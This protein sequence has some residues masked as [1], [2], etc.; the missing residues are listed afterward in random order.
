MEEEEIIESLTIQNSAL[1]EELGH[2]KLR[3]SQLEQQLIQQQKEYERRF[4]LLLLQKEQLEQNEQFEKQKLEQNKQ[5]EKQKSEQNEQLEQH[6]Q[7]RHSFPNQK[8]ST[9]P[10][11]EEKD[12]DMNSS[13]IFHCDKMFVNVMIA[14][15]YK[16]EALKLYEIILQLLTIANINCSLSEKCQQTINLLNAEYQNESFL[17]CLWDSEPDCNIYYKVACI[18]MLDKFLYSCTNIQQILCSSNHSNYKKLFERIRAAK[19]SGNFELKL[20]ELD[21]SYEESNKDRILKDDSLFSLGKAELREYDSVFESVKQQLHEKESQQM[22]CLQEELRDALYKNEIMQTKLD[23]VT[24]ELHQHGKA[25]L[26]ETFKSTLIART[27]SKSQAGSPQSVSAG[28]EVNSLDLMQ[29]KAD[30]QSMYQR[31]LH[32]CTQ[33]RHEGTP[34]SDQL[35]PAIKQRYSDFNKLATRALLFLS[36]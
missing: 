30:V 26:I 2:E 35:Y 17:T 7:L 5:F 12:L 20:L 13:S 24:K 10:S 11:K 31:C 33:T 14:E 34:N 25:R 3:T 21:R 4:N 6:E 18:L 16:R 8:H 32:Y 1:Q 29:V 27:A 15:V 22:K 23:K 9:P 19:G 28:S 36:E